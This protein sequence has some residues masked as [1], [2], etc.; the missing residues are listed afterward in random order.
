MELLWAN[1]NFMADEENRDDGCFPLEYRGSCD[2]SANLL[3]LLTDPLHNLA[4]GKCMGGEQ[5]ENRARK[6]CNDNVTKVLLE[7]SRPERPLPCLPNQL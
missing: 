7:R 1:H 2:G 6:R 5:R 3:R 4:A